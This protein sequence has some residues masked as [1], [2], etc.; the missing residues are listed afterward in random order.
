MFAIPLYAVS[1]RAAVACRPR[2]HKCKGGRRLGLKAARIPS[3]QPDSKPHL[4]Y[5]TCY[6]CG[7]V[8]GASADSRPWMA[9][10]ARVVR[11]VRV[12]RL[13]RRWLQGQRTASATRKAASTSQL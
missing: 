11:V 7:G 12:V 4:L 13:A 10:V 1:G 5:Y 2:R 6:T 8:D 3:S 9:R